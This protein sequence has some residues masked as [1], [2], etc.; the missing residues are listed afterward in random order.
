MGTFENGV[1]VAYQDPTPGEENESYEYS[2]V[3]GVPVTFHMTEEIL[4]VL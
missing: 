3:L 1:Y 4:Q 2:G